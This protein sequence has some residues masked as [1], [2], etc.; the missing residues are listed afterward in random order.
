MKKT[1]FVCSTAKFPDGDAGSIYYCNLVKCMTNDLDCI[2]MIGAGNT[3]YSQVIKDKKTG[4]D[5]LSLR[6][7]S[8]YISR[9]ISHFTIKRKIIDFIF[10]HCADI[11]LL[12]MDGTFSLRNYKRVSRFFKKHNP[13]AKIVIGILERYQKE[14]FDNRLLMSNMIRNNNNFIDKFNEKKCYIVCIS[15]YLEELFV[16]RGFRCLRVPFIFDATQSVSCEE[17][18][19][20][21]INDGKV[22]F[23]YAGAPSKKDLIVDIING[24]SLLPDSYLNKIEIYL[25][26][27]TE[28]WLFKHGLNKTVLIKLSNC[29]KVLGRLPHTDVEKYYMISDY[30]LLARDENK[31]FAKAGFP[32]KISESLFY[33]IVPITNLT[34][35]LHLYLEDG[36][37]SVIIKGHSPENISLAVMNA[38]DCYSN[39]KKMRI[40][41][42][43]VLN[44]ELS[45]QKFSS[46]VKEFLKL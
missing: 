40:S 42:N 38:V 3:D 15:S 44:Q 19:N 8:N 34:S 6:K 12:L 37:N 21:L 30:S 18:C 25:I 29:L 5:I 23:I 11:E 2:L 32:T 41:V 27:V 46:E 24:L 14:E 45:I 17:K 43:E 33:C 7:H 39:I 36:V 22:R 16:K 10:K 26:G 4:L 9:V 20:N 13:N 35:D 1:I 31:C 28:N